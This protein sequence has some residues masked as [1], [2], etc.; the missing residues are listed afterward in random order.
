MGAW[1][2]S[3]GAECGI[4][5]EG[6]SAAGDAHW[7]S[8]TG[9]VAAETSVVRSGSKSHR[10]DAAATR[11][12]LAPPVPAS[13]SVLYFRHYF[14]TTSVA[15][16]FLVVLVLG[17]IAQA[18]ITNRLIV[19]RDA[20]QTASNILANE[21]LYRTGFTL[22]MLEM[23]AQIAQTVLMFHLLKPVNR[24]VATLA[25]AF[26]LVGCTIKTFARVLYLAPLFVLKQKTFGAFAGDQLPGLSLMLLSVMDRGA[27]VA[28]GFFGLE[29]VLE[30]WL[31]L[32][33]T[34]LPR[35]LGVLTIVAGAGWLAFL[36][37]TL[38]YTIFNAIALIALVAS[39]ITI[40]W[41]L[42]KGVDEER[43]YALAMSRQP[44]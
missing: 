6:S 32:R 38:G 42:V 15:L 43:W 2:L 35:W 29:T 8:V 4:L 7:S 17:T 25:L 37:P 23:A 14:R 3:C 34:F 20:A 36:T 27:G 21:P 31:V 41:F 40:G 30:G 10:F 18:F 1:F 24:R 16:L 44:G 5:D 39:L 19:F 9:V 11:P 28:L 13:Q 33:S 12:S 22:F 26:G